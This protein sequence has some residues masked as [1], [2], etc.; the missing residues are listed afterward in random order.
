MFSRAKL[1]HGD[2]AMG[3]GCEVGGESIWSSRLLPTFGKRGLVWIGMDDIPQ[4]DPSANGHP[5]WVLAWSSL[6]GLPA[7]P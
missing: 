4:A 2:Q 6:G 7:S 3:G 5:V 1:L